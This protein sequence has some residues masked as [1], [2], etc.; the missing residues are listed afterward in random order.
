MQIC[1][2]YLRYVTVCTVCGD[3]PPKRPPCVLQRSQSSPLSLL[4]A[5]SAFHLKI[6]KCF[7]RITIINILKMKKNDSYGRNLE[8]TKDITSF[9]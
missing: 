4:V 1:G 6:F 3:S 9:L 7:V 5:A 2:L 8:Y